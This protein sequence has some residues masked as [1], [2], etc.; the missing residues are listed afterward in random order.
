MQAMRE[1]WVDNADA[2]PHPVGR[3]EAVN[4]VYDEARAAVVAIYGTVRDFRPFVKA[5]SLA[6]AREVGHTSESTNQEGTEQ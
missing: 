3:S 6:H 2:V 1:D 4:L 5:F